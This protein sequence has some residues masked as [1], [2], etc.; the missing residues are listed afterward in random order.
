[1]NYELQTTN[2]E[3]FTN[4][5]DALRDTHNEIMQNKPNLVRR[6]RIRNECKLLLYKELRLSAE[7]SA[8]AETMKNKPKQSQTNPTCSELAC[9]ELVEVSNLFGAQNTP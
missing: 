3:P 5:H 4:T 8:K 2:Y 9:T 1:M 7:A 6:R